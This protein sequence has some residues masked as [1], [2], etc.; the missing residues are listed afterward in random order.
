MLRGNLKQ[1]FQRGGLTALN[2]KALLPALVFAK[3]P[4]FAT[5]TAGA[6]Q[7]L[8][9]TEEIA[10]IQRNAKPF[11]GGFV[12]G[13][14]TSGIGTPFGWQPPSWLPRGTQGF[15][16]GPRVGLGWGASVGANW[17]TFSGQRHIP[18]FPELP[19]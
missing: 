4:D 16:I 12:A 13:A 19:F 1:A 17:A 14:F 6:Y 15:F 5:G 18:S 3:S 7:G 10:F 11:G 8:F 2:V 9:L